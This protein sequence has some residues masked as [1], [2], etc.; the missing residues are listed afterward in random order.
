MG[1]VGAG[2]QGDA[3]DAARYIESMAKELKGLADKADL[4]FLAYLLAMVE[5]EAASAGRGPKGSAAEEG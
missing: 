4:D 5:N 3:R 1:T 2:V